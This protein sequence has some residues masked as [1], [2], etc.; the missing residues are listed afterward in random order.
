[1]KLYQQVIK[2]GRGPNCRQAADKYAPLYL[3]LLTSPD[4]KP[5]TG[6]RQIAIFTYFAPGH[7]LELWPCFPHFEHLYLLL[8]TMLASLESCD[9]ILSSCSCDTS[10][11]FSLISSP[12]LSCSLPFPPPIST[13][14]SQAH[15]SIGSLLLGSVNRLGVT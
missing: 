9:G 5:S 7:L 11:S 1:M 8:C 3:S 12:L 13:G 2:E 10:S 15:S 4:C 14:S 6:C